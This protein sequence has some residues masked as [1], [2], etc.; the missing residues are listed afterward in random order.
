MAN[1]DKILEDILNA[2]RTEARTVFSKRVYSDQPIIQTGRQ[3][4]ERAEQ[5]AAGEGSA[6]SASEAE[7]ARRKARREARREEQ[8]A[9]EAA[10][11]AARRAARKVREGEPG[12]TRTRPDGKSTSSTA[13]TL[14]T[15]PPTA[16]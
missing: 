14:S 5:G 4:R 8:A 3:L 16:P 1:V 9:R 13:H 10:R 12:I 11:Q 15:S 7:A 6:R 2:A